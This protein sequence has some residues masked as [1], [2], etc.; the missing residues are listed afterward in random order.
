M[1]RPGFSPRTPEDDQFITIKCLK[2]RMGGLFAL[3][4][5]WSGAT[6]DIYELNDEQFAQ[7]KEIR[8]RQDKE[9]EAVAASGNNWT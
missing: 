9:K 4:L 2:N 8:E 6:G 1:S 7:L 3:D 5:G